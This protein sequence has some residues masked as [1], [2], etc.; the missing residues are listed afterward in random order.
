M[1]IAPLPKPTT[2]RST[3]W[4]SFSLRAMFALMTVCCIVLGVWSV[5]VDPFRRQAQSLAAVHR[6]QGQVYIDPAKG[7]AWQGWLVRKLLGDKAFVHVTKVD[8]SL[9][10]VGDD[11]LRS[12]AG[13]TFLK[14]LH[15]DYT[16]VTDDGI[17][18]LGSMRD[19]TD[20]SLRYTS[21]SDRG[22][23][24]LCNLPRL[25][26]LTVTGTQVSDVAVEDLARLKSLGELY[27]RWT[28]VTESGARN[29]ERMLP[30]CSV[31]F[32]VLDGD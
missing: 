26:K 4:R 30:G 29:I 12:F 5:Y 10:K 24:S 9:G 18:A 3:R 14:E 7:P 20:L 1:N 31:Y 25:E 27:I 15:L 19:L 32:H 13:L 11:E 6:L 17:A 21:L 28:R 2:T 8:L 16:K 23:K 22:L